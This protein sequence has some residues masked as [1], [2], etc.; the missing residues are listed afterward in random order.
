[1]KNQTEASELDTTYDSS[2]QEHQEKTNATRNGGLTES[3]K[4]GAEP[5]VQ[6]L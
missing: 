5:Y 3:P 6:F 4:V 2:I 1:M